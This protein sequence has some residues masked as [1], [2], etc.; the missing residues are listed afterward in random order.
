MLM[1]LQD[2]LGP[3]GLRCLRIQTTQKAMAST[4]E[5]ASYFTGLAHDLYG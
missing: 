5:T 3:L 4:S 1:P 2:Y